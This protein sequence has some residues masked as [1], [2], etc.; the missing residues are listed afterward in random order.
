LGEAAAISIISGLLSSAS[1]KQAV[2]ML[3]TAQRKSEAVA[4]SGV[5]VDF[6]GVTNSQSPHPSVWSASGEFKENWVHGSG[7]QRLVHNGDEF[8]NVETDMGAI[9]IRWGQVAAYFPPEQSPD[10]LIET[11]ETNFIQPKP[12]PWA[13]GTVSKP[14]E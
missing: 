12:V 13:K 8:V 10:K 9:C 14:D 2:E 11:I 5:Y 7:R 6:A 4:K 3:Q 1:Q